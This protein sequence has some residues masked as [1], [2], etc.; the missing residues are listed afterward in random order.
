MEKQNDFGS[1]FEVTED[2]TELIEEKREVTEQLDVVN[3]EKTEEL[4][5]ILSNNTDNSFNTVSNNPTDEI[6]INDIDD[7]FSNLVKRRD[8]KGKVEINTKHHGKKRKLKKWVYILILLL[9]LGGGFGAY[10]IYSDKK[11]AQEKEEHDKK[12]AE[13]EKHYNEFVKVIDD[14]IIYEKKDNDYK[15]IGKVYKGVI[16]SLEEEKI[17]VDT[18]YFHVK[19]LD[20]YIKYSDVEK[21]EEEKELD[22]RYKSYLPFNINIVTKDSFTMNFDKEKY[23][24][25]DKSME[26]PV[27][28]NDYDNK[29]YV[30]YNNRLVNIAK[31]DVE[32]TKE[33][34]NTEKKNQAKM[35]TLAYH[36]VYDT[37]DKCTDPYVCIK[38]ESFDKQ[39]KYL[40]DNKYLTLTLQEMY[41]YLKGN[42]QVEKGVVITFDDGYLFNASDEVLAKYG[43]N[44]TMFVISGD[45]VGK[46]DRF[47]GLKAIEI[48]SHTHS[49]HKNYVCAGGNQGGKMLCAGKD[50]IVADLKKSF[51]ALKIEPFG[52]AYPFYDYN[53]VAISGVKEA[54][55]K[56]AFVGRAGVMGRATPKVTDL[57][58]V[59]R[60][61]VY[62]ESLMS[63]NAWKGY[64]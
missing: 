44:G 39:M 4:I 25:F 37:T 43:L 47:E 60:M 52:F 54:G 42:L 46:Y 11:K 2:F 8:Y 19:D 41:M 18:K 32:K 31:D 56:I 35:T 61:T 28:I 9:L 64:L 57:Y 23:L 29:Y 26:F 22:S 1:N 62:E 14:A 10:K 48:Q 40:S 5:G 27:I 30:E 49:M 15:E 38:K 55:I 45:F 53:D 51:E 12:I 7:D 20:F 17:D 6:H 63:F 13:I 50:A 34:K 21:G 16:L 33:N 24:T 3:D 58:K 59:P 36:R